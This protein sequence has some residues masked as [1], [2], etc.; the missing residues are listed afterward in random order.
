MLQPPTCDWKGYNSRGGQAITWTSRC[1]DHGGRIRESGTGFGTER[2]TTPLVDKDC[3]DI[4]LGA[5]SSCMS[6]G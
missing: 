4:V 2:E 6:V 5:G 1:E 3:V